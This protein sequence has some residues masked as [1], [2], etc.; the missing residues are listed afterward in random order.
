MLSNKTTEPPAG[1]G[2][3]R[4]PCFGS[5][6]TAQRTLEGVES[7]HMM[8]K[9]QVKRLKCRGVIGQAKFVASLFGVAA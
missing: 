1:E 7:M 5:C 9:G 8:K 6:H 4:L 3:G 2:G